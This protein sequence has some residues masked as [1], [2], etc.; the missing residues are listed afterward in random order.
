MATTYIVNTILDSL[1]TA[2]DAIAGQGKPL[3]QVVDRDVLPS[4]RL[5]LGILPSE[6]YRTGGP[7]GERS[8]E[9]D[10]LLPLAVCGDGQADRFETVNEVIG[11]IDA[12]I[13]AWDVAGGNY[14]SVDRYRWRYWVV[15]GKNSR[16]LPVGAVGS[17]RV[18]FDGPLK[19]T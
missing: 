10:L 14:C 19:R 18:S 2:L 1:K 13:E 15:A 6:A 8:W 3:R 5:V 17:L 7:A 9:M 11:E 12:A 16:L 4:E